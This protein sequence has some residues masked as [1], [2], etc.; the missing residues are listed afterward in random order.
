MGASSGDYLFYRSAAGKEASVSTTFVATGA[1]GVTLIPITGSTRQI[2]V[3]SIRFVPTTFAA[4][5]LTFGETA[6]GTGVFATLVQPAAAY[7]PTGAAVNFGGPQHIFLDFGAKGYALAAGTS[8]FMVR[9]ATG[10]AGALVVEAYETTSG[11]V[12]MGTTN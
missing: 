8:L 12:A 11:A 5:T 7:A 9:S 10:S 6:S 1:T 4:G 3:Q 2:H